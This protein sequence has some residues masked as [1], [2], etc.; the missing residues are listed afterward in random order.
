[1]IFKKQKIL[2]LI[3]FSF[4]FP[5]TSIA[6]NLLIKSLGHSSFLIKGK[7]TSILLNPFKAIGC[8]SDLKEPKEVKADLILASSRLADEGYNPNSKL[9]FVEPG[10]YKF[11]KILLN[12][13]GMCKCTY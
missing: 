2:F 5:A 4:F 1:M 13:T 7:E 11:G 10:V 6:G 8:A 12:G 9:M 3:L